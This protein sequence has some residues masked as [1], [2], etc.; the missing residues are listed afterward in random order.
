MVSV[1]RSA[2]LP[3]TG[4]VTDFHCVAAASG[5]MPLGAS[6]SPRRSGSFTGSWSSGTGTSPQLGQWMIG[7]GQPQ[8]RWRD[9]SQSRRR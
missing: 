7:I 8:K 1:S 6:A 4:Q 3:H 2:G 5:E 9:S